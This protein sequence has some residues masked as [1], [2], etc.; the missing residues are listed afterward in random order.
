MATG[1][2]RASYEEKCCISGALS[3]VD[4][5]IEMLGEKL[6]ALEK[7]KCGL[8]QKLLTGEARVK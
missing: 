7:Q 2:L 8:M 6:T 4:V 1:G 5:N 3:E